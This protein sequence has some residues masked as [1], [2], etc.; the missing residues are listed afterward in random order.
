VCRDVERAGGR[1]E[2][3]ALTEALTFFLRFS[4]R[5]LGLEF[6]PYYLTQVSAFRLMPKARSIV[7]LTSTWNWIFVDVK[8]LGNIRNIRRKTGTEAPIFIKAD[9]IR[10]C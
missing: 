9:G 8:C 5:E 1:E 4:D 2:I 7:L 6:G 10:L 3:E